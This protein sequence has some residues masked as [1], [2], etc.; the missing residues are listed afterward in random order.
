MTVSTEHSR[1]VLSA[2]YQGWSGFVLSS[3]DRAEPPVVF[4]P[5]PDEPL[6]PI[7]QV[8]AITHGHPEHVLGALSHLRRAQRAPVT[9]VASPG[10]CRYFARH[11]A[12]DDDRFVPVAAGDSVAV[13]RWRIRVFSWRH[14]PLLPPGLG[15]ALRH[16]TRLLTHPIHTIRIALQSVGGPSHGPMIGFQVCCDSF[17]SVVY[18]G[19]GLHREST[20]AELDA[21]LGGVPV[22]AL[23]AG[24]EPEDSESIPELLSGRAISKVVLFEPHRI[25]RKRFGM[26]LADLAALAARLAGLGLCVNLPAADSARLDVG[27]A[28]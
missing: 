3:P 13:R 7:E 10:V 9:V 15:P 11:S 25:W 4:D 14:M 16:L 27:G 6:A 5:S 8:I 23:V 12:R 21:A 24:V 28:P 2:R 1:L 26:P 17:D 20:P 19:E 22:G 18:L